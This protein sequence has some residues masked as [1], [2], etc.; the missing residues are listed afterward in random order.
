MSTVQEARSSC[1][2]TENVKLSPLVP[3][4]TRTK[5]S[6]RGQEVTSEDGECEGESYG[7]SVHKD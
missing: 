2:R 5:V 7:A 6:T 1:L 3:P 4:F